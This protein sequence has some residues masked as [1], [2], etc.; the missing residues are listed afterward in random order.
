ML[1]DAH[2]SCRS[3]CET[4]EL[5]EFSSR[6]RV[7]KTRSADLVA[8][9]LPHLHQALQQHGPHA[10][11][12][13]HKHLTAPP[14]ISPQGGHS[15]NRLPAKP[16]LPGLDTCQL[17]RD[18]CFD[19]DHFASMQDHDD[20]FRG[21]SMQAAATKLL[22][23]DH[24]LMVQAGATRHRSSLL[25][26]TRCTAYIK[27]SRQDRPHETRGQRLLLEHVSGYISPA[28][29]MLGDRSDGVHCFGKSQH[30]HGDCSGL[31][32]GCLRPCYSCE[33]VWQ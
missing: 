30:H 6:A 11:A 26:C 17:T 13:I 5:P 31:W 24:L 20:S 23:P 10:H 29:G 4:R 25:G 16:W 18:G 22:Q 28:R 7:E 9:L 2:C 14:E 21:I 33:T 15:P 19:I 27:P 12:Y 8:H 32:P 1:M 3:A